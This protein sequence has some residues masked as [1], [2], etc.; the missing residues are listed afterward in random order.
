MPSY[1]KHKFLA[2]MYWQKYQKGSDEWY[3]KEKEFGKE[4]W[5]SMQPELE[6]EFRKNN[7]QRNSIEGG[8]RIK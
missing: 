2:R 3:Q 5:A 6:E 8:I 1:N 7:P 4:V